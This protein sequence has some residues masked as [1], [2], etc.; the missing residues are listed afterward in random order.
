MRSKKTFTLIE[1][2]VTLGLM[3]ILSSF[4]VIEI[5]KTI[6]TLSFRKQMDQIDEEL[7]RAVIQGRIAKKSVFI[8][9][10]NSSQGLVL[11]IE[12]D[13]KLKTKKNFS[14]VQLIGETTQFYRLDPQLGPMEIKLSLGPFLEKRG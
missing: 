13:Q 8:E 5:K 7:A 4:F 1:I 12:F 14:R 9:A 2:L 6:E 10:M 3:A 11:T